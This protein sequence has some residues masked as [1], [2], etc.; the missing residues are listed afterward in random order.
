M[1]QNFEIRRAQ[2][3][4][5]PAFVQMMSD[6]EVFGGLLQMPYPVESRWRQLLD[7]QSAM[8]KTDLHLVAVR[9]GQL[10]G[11][12]GI[13]PAGAALRRRHAM[14]LGISVVMAEQGQGVGSALMA[15]LI[16]YAD[17]WG[18]VLRLE[19]TV[20]ADNDRAIRLYERFGFEREGLFKA[21][22]MR[23][24]RYVDTVCMARLHPKPPT[25]R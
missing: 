8:G 24:G 17:N 2:P 12:A 20:Y 9:D 15:A 1:P 7:E 25:L 3:Y 6:P 23:D 14:M 21:Y 19:L 18:Q 22:A 10:L 5:A 13:H 11:S 4:D 16:D